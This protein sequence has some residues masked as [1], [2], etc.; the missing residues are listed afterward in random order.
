MWLLANPGLPSMPVVK[1]L[2]VAREVK[3]TTLVAIW[4]VFMMAMEW[5]R[6]LLDLGL[7]WNGKRILENE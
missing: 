4:N 7:V 1:H 6:F 3:R 5:L 2:A